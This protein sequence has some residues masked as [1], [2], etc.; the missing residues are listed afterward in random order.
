MSF[1]DFLPIFQLYLMYQFVRIRITNN[2]Y[3]V[4]KKKKT[5][6]NLFIRYLFVV[7]VLSHDHL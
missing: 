2:Y 5:G 1:S 7:L 4:N 3:E 6:L